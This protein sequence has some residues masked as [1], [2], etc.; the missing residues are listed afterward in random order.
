VDIKRERGP[1]GPIK[2]V[3]YRAGE[4]I[5]KMLKGKIKVREAP[6]DSCYDNGKVITTIRLAQSAP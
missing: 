2:V 3:E 4:F 6:V 1:I 5:G